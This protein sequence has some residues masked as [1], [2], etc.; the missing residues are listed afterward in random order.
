M[1]QFESGDIVHVSEDEWYIR[2]EWAPGCRITEEAAQ[3]AMDQ[4]NTVCGRRRRP[5]LVDMIEVESVTRP[6]RAV[7]TRPCQANIIALLGRS[8]VDRVIANFVLGVSNLPTPT[9]YFNAEA[10]ALAWLREAR[11]AGS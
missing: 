9:R 6:A 8:P 11:G 4:V 1:K 10:Q 2:L 3:Q 5:M 7:F